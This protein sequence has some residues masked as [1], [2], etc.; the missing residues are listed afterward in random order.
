MAL[1]KSET[2]R[3]IHAPTTLS[4]VGG[5]TLGVA[6]L[7]ITLAVMSG[8]HRD[9]RE[10]ILGIQPHIVVVIESQRPFTEYPRIADE[11]RR[12][13]EVTTTSPFIYGQILLRHDAATSGA[14]VKGIDFSGESKLVHLDRQ[15]QNKTA[16]FSMIGD[17]DIILGKELAGNIGARTGEE[18]ILMSP[19]QIGVIPKMEKFR[20]IALFHSGMYEYDSSLT[21][22]SL[23]AGQRLF[24][25]DNAV[26][27]LGVAVRNWDRAGA[28]E[29]QLQQSLSYPYWVRSWERMNYNLFAALKLEK[30]MMFIILALIILVAAFNIISNLLLLTVEKAK[31]IGIM[32][33][34]GLPRLTIGR[35]FFYEGLII[36]VSGILMGVGLGTGI[37]YLLKKY[38]FI[39]LPPDVYYLDTLPVL[40]NPVDIATVVLAAIGITLVASIYPAYQVTKLDPLEA[41]RYG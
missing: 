27:G 3:S 9:I 28:V 32:S 37:S 8:F 16:D 39:H 30:I 15:L 4:T 33:A 38:Q 22:I 40:L 1:F 11:T 12:N 24:G 41:I 35:I 10:K 18:V 14:V 19:S 20:V 5:I 34:L 25:L 31:E 29:K 17:H 36:G 21:Y 26:S 6:S 23:T 7:I 2:E 13:S